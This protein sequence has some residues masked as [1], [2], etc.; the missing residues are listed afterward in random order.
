[1]RKP[2]PTGDASNRPQNFGTPSR[3]TRQQS[4]MRVPE[5]GRRPAWNSIQRLLTTQRQR[6]DSDI[7]MKGLVR[8]QAK[9][10]AFGEITFPLLSRRD[11]CLWA[12]PSVSDAILKTRD[13]S[14]RLI[15]CRFR[16]FKTGAWPRSFP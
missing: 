1:M 13:E 8:G 10:R 16:S 7:V 4:S 11:R 6:R 5:S 12:K 3:F 14:L 15:V 9:P 2:F